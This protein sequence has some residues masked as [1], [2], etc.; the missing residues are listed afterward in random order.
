MPR[1]PAKPPPAPRSARAKADAIDT[2]LYLLAAGAYAGI[3]FLR[4]R[5]G[6]G[7]PRAARDRAGVV[8]RSCGEAAKLLGERFGSPGQ[9]IVGLRTVDSR[10][11]EPVA[12]PLSIALALL[13]LGGGL[14]RGRLAPT[15]VAGPTSEARADFEREL[16]EMRERHADDPQARDAAVLELY[17]ERKLEPTAVTLPF[18]RALVIGL[19]I[20]QA[21]RRLRRRLAPTTVVLARRER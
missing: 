11:G 2:A 4:A 8:F 5:D 6:G 9:R 3:R 10:S 12:L 17:R 20:G 19:A 15:T 7:A 1:A 21:N 14:L 13:T 16:R 18:A